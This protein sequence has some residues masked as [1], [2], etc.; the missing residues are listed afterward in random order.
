MLGTLIRP[1][2][3]YGSKTWPL[4]KIK[5]D[6]LLIPERNIF[7]RK[8]FGQ[9]KDKITGDWRRKKNKELEV[10]YSKNNILE[11][12]KKIKIKN[13]VTGWS[14][15]ERLLRGVLEQNSILKIPLGTPRMRRKDVVN[16]GVEALVG[17]P[18]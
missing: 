10:M 13:T 16:K 8:I 7:E 14:C 6:K 12:I 4:R 1:N 5:G 9:K 11:I 2:I 18:N 3:L 17:G 15:T